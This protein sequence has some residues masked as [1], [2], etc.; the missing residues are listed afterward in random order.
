MRW[1]IGESF[2]HWKFVH[3]NVNVFFKGHGVSTLRPQDIWLADAK[4]Y[5]VNEEDCK[6]THPYNYD[7][8]KVEVTYF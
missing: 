5:W 8:E 4:N 6:Y 3:V 7:E 2:P 1:Y